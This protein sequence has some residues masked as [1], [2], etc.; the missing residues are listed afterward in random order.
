[1]SGREEPTGNT[2]LHKKHF[3]TFLPDSM[4]C[5][6]CSRSSRPGVNQPSISIQSN[7]GKWKSCE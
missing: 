5:R 2:H 1:M 7:K 4:S 6:Q 3:S